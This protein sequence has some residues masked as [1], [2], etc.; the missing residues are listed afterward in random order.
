MIVIPSRGRPDSLQ[1]FFDESEPQEIGVIV[2]DDDD[3]HRYVNLTLPNGWSC[4]VG[5]RA[6]Y[7]EL[8]NRAFCLFPNEPWYAYGGDDVL[9]RPVGWDTFL[10]QAAGADGLAYGDDG[11]NGEKACCLPF[12]G[13]D[14]VRRAGWLACPMFGHLYSDTVWGEISRS[15]GVRR[16]FPEIITEHLHWSVGKQL[17]DNT[18]KE[19]RTAGDHQAF[20][21]FMARD[22]GETIARCKS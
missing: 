6:S 14:L 8:M 10:A 15:L 5:P 7:V 21:V 12:I 1:R 17:Y 19:R 13:G 9:A 2:L 18:A 16:Y 20:A 3:A 4:L 22:L 11:I